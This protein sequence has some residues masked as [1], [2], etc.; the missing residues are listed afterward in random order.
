LEQFLFSAGSAPEKEQWWENLS[1]G[2]VTP[3]SAHERLAS[4]AI[5]GLLSVALMGRGI[6]MH[7]LVGAIGAVAG[8]GCADQ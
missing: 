5:S 6:F 2:S 8:C 7:E 4:M 1:P 3:G